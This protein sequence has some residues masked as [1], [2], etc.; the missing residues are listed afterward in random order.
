MPAARC[1]GRRRRRR[2]AVDPGAL[3]AFGL[4]LTAYVGWAALAGKD[5]TVNPA[6]G[7]FYV[8]LW[9]GM[10][11]LSLLVGN[12]WPLLSPMRTLHLGLTRVMRI[13]PEA[14]IARYPSWLG[15]WPAAAGP[16]RVR[17]DRAGR[18]RLGLRLHR[19]D[20]G[21]AVRGGDAGRR[22]RVRHPVVRAGRPVRGLLRAGGAA[23]A[24]GPAAR[25]R[26]LVVR[27]PLD[28]LDGVVVDRGLLAVVSV[29]LGSTAFD[30]FAASTYWL[31]K[32]A[33]PGEL[34]PELRDT[35]VLLGFVAAGRGVVRAGGDGGGGGRPGA[36]AGC[37]GCWRTRWCRSSWAT[38]SRTT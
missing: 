34:D 10:V 13:P 37:R 7:V 21:A 20:L 19:A 15:Y 4:A 16:V 33:R 14:G 9:V 12:V 3:G 5:V 31:A 11:P 1:R 28:G 6:I 32:T 30:S 2:L 26:R 29:L 17:V 24:V 38:C 27:N 23:V 36:P 35:L 8:Y 22:R 18:P 25:R